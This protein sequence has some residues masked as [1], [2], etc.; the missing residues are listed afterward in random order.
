MPLLITKLTE[1]FIIKGRE[2]TM[3]FKMRF[4]HC[5]VKEALLCIMAVSW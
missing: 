1:E 3:T 5:I 4:D 2:N